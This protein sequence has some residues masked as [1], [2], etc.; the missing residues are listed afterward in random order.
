MTRDCQCPL[1]SAMDPVARRQTIVGYVSHPDWRI[2]EWVASGGWRLADDDGESLARVLMADPHPTVRRSANESI[3]FR[4]SDRS[5][6]LDMRQHPLDWFTA[7]GLPDPDVSQR[8]CAERWDAAWGAGPVPIALLEDPLC[9]IRLAVV[10]HQHAVGFPVAAHI[11]SWNDP[12]PRVRHVTRG[13]SAPPTELDLA[14]VTADEAVTI[15]RATKH[16]AHLVAL[17]T[18]PDSRVRFGIAANPSCP[19]DVLETL[20]RD[21]SSRVRGAAF[22]NPSWPDHLPIP[23]PYAGREDELPREPFGLLGAVIGT[24]TR[25][26]CVAGRSP[27]FLPSAWAHLN[28]DPV[29]ACDLDAVVLHTWGPFCLDHLALFAGRRQRAGADGFLAQRLCSGV[30][31]GLNRGGPFRPASELWQG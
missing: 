7:A 25:L 11:L 12:C 20:S 5:A 13:R 6:W 17:H 26:R 18:H 28:P 31:V 24:R 14:V 21:E 19:R 29:G 27:S 15:V 22:A 3:G 2:R 1:D 8:S 23:A 4:L 30:W 10:Q 16:P 9:G